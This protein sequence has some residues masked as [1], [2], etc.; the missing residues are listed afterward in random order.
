MSTPEQ[1][2]LGILQDQE[3]PLNKTEL[4]DLTGFT[5]T[6]VLKALG[7]LSKHHNI[8][9][10]IAGYKLTTG[11]AAATDAVTQSDELRQLLT[12][13]TRHNKAF[14]PKAIREELSWDKRYTAEMLSKCKQMGLV[15]PKNNGVY[16]LTPDGVQYVI[17]HYP[18][19]EVKAFVLDKAKEQAMHFHIVAPHVKAAKQQQVQASE[20]A[21]QQPHPAIAQARSI[22]ATLKLAELPTKNLPQLTEVPVKIQVLD[23]LAQCF[24]N[25]VQIQLQQLSGFLREYGH[26]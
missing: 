13:F 22:S 14:L 5:Q 4:E 7:E 12:F 25:D 1:T 6:E 23:E 21:K 24:G 10:S 11:G 3:D 26:G 19:V 2:I 8:A 16:Y 18:D 9:K 20:H 15:T 17:K